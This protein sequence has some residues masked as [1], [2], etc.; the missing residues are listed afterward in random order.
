[1]PVLAAEHVIAAAAE[2]QKSNFALAGPA[3][4]G[5]RLCCLTTRREISRVKVMLTK[6]KK[7]HAVHSIQHSHT[8]S[9]NKKKKKA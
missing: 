5:I 6:R 9:L 1:M 2:S 3:F 8:V 7:K 4:R